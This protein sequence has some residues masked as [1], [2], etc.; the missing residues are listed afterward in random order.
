MF[1]KRPGRLGIAGSRTPIQRAIAVLRRS[2]TNAHIYLPG[3]GMLNGLQ[4][5]NYLESTGTTAGV[6]DQ[7]V[8]LVQDT[9]GG[10]HASQAAAANRPSLRRGAL[11]LQPFSHD[12][13]A[14]GWSVV[15]ITKSTGSLTRAST[16][17]AYSGSP[18]MAASMPIGSKFTAAA[19]VKAKSL[20]GR[21]ALRPTGTYP[22]RVDAVFDIVAGTVVGVVNGGAFPV[23]TASISGPDANGFYLCV[24]TGTVGGTSLV[25]LVLGPTD[26]SLTTGGWEGGSTVLSDCFISGA[27]LFAGTLTAAQI[28][29]LGGIPLTTTAPASTA[30]G[31]Y[32]WDTSGGKSLTA[33]FPAGNESVTVIDARPTGQVTATVQSVVGSYNASAALGVELASTYATVNTTGTGATLPATVTSA[34]AGTSGIRT[35]ANMEIGKTY[36]ITVTW[37]GNTAN[38][39]IKIACGGD[40]SVTPST[41]TTGTLT[42]VLKATSGTDFGW[43]YNTAVAASEVFRVTAFSVREVN[44]INGKIIINGALTAPDLLLLQ[45][46]ANRLAGL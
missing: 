30:L 17:A 36:Q 12:V 23:G 25:N 33:T 10:I 14:A 16:G 42:A 24:A 37:D 46:F 28:Q 2:G 5:G 9:L 15:N 35:S 45:N 19:L 26:S 4:A 27:A 34:A 22:D 21:F 3:V 32:S 8:G 29:A 7:P 1:G 6:V 13:M 39:P 43:V 20:G 38:R 40:Y 11:N 44:P 41:A 18:A 31:P